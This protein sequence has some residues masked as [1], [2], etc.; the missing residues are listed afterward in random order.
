MIRN[1]N[2]TKYKTKYNTILMWII[3]TELDRKQ[4]VMIINGYL[5][6]TKNGTKYSRISISHLV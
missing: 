5:Y 6:T 1:G 3:C 2:N 4:I